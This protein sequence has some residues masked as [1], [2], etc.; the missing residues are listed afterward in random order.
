MPESIQINLEIP[1]DLAQF[2]MPSGVNRRL[3]A[4]LDRQDQGIPLTVDERCEAEG[5]V[6]LADLL[7]MLRLRAERLA[8]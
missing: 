3:Q 8:E 2:R 5:L 6:N 4:L 1:D 7:T